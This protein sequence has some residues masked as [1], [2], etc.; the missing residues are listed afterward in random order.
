MFNY[1]PVFI[2]AF[3]LSATALACA[4]SAPAAGS[5]TTQTQGLAAD[6]ATGADK[7]PG[8]H[9]HG[10]PPEAFAACQSKAAG[11]ACTISFQEKTLA[12]TCTAPPAGAPDARVFCL[13]KDMPPPPP[14]GPHGPGGPPPPKN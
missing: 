3:A 1:R 13:P 5:T 4:E 8:Q 10:P 11:D 2:A 9:P 12:G 14:G 7:G 6:G